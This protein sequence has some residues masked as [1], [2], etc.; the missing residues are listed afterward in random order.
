M[1]FQVKISERQVPASSD[2]QQ[3][4]AGRRQTYMEKVHFASVLYYAPSTIGPQPLWKNSYKPPLRLLLL[5]QA[6]RA[7][8]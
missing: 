2:N 6:L 8:S 7:L 3:P 4:H 5:S 1:L